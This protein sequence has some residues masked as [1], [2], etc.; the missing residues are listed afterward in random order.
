MLDQVT[1][2]SSGIK[3]TL[4][5]QS[6][7]G[8]FATHAQLFSTFQELVMD[9]QAKILDPNKTHLAETR[10]IARIE[11]PTNDRQDNYRDDFASRDANR[12][13][14]DDRYSADD[15]VSNRT[16]DH[17]VSQRDDAGRDYAENRRDDNAA[18]SDGR[19]DAA[20]NDRGPSDDQRQDAVNRD[21]NNDRGDNS[22][23]EEGQ[24]TA[25][26]AQANTG[27]N[28]GENAGPQ[29]H[30]VNQGA[31]TNVVQ[32][33]VTNSQV[34]TL[35]ATIVAQNLGSEQGQQVA[36]V[37]KSLGG[38][39]SQIVQQNGQAQREGNHGLAQA[40]N[41]QAQSLR[42]IANLQ[43]NGQAS[44]DGA[45]QA[46]TLLQAQAGEI[47][48]AAGGDAKLMVNV[49][50]KD[51]AAAL[52]LRPT[53]SLTAASA[54][55]ANKDVMG[56]SGPQVQAAQQGQTQN[57][58]AQAALVQN[59]QN[60]G[61]AQATQGQAQNGQATQ[62]QAASQLSADAKGPIQAGS[63]VN[64]AGTHGAN[65][66]NEGNSTQANA[67]TNQTQQAQ[68]ASQAQKAAH[69]EQP[70][71]A[72]RNKVIDQVSVQINKA[73]KAGADRINIRLFPTDLGR[74]DVRLE[75][76]NDGRTVAVVTAEKPETLEMLRRDS[77]SLA[78][79]LADA[80]LDMEAGDLN[81]N[82][83]GQDEGKE[84][85]SVADGSAN[86]DETVEDDA[87]DTNLMDQAMAAHEMGV[88]HNGRVD[89]RA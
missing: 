11:R 65:S 21:G 62:A 68:Q 64:N 28:N 70:Q 12:D 61:Q 32:A 48:K 60:P 66:G 67:N 56:Q 72:A 29:D 25:D 26:Q 39:V 43:T 75:V 8:R 57:P 52:N 17:S 7:A 18:A 73:I 38:Q 55:A 53:A 71:Q 37:A 42:A 44:G 79:A 30:P 33:S 6:Q 22:Q 41:Q 16:D 58:L 27:A 49:N 40:T 74:V 80:G 14:S 59:H 50:V 35:L 24:A 23:G 36:E 9:M 15:R 46:E 78:K 89:V 20:N 2:T 82:L 10:N 31:Q 51:D 83:K 19:N 45:K 1:A 5:A 69:Q 63:G 4:A 88:L 3:Q 54:L 34:Q 47:A 84:Q 87:L 76:A 81:Y 77:D 13:P 86:A 85:K